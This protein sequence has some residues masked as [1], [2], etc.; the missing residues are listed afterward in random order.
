VA[1]P[2]PAGD[3]GVAE[4]PHDRP[5]VA[6]RSLSRMGLPLAVAVIAAAASLPGATGHALY[7][8]E[9]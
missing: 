4:R 2:L 9:R 8:A 7:G 6:G 5:H 1:K 3:L